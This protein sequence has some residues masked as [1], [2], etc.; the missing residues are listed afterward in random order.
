VNAKD[1][2]GR[3]ALM[4]A[5]YLGHKEVVKLLLE[6][7]ADVNTRDKDGFTAL[8]LA[9]ENGHKE[10]IELLKSYGARE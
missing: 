3:T 6:A 8:T 7:G 10:I 1:E 4:F 5:S 2:Y 9:S